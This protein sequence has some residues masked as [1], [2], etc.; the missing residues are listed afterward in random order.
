MEEGFAFSGTNGYRASKLQY[1]SDV[2]K[3]LVWEYGIQYN[4]AKKDICIL[5]EGLR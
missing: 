3:E 2:V 5:E 4:L 1:V